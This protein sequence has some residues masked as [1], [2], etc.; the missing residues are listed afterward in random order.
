MSSGDSTHILLAPSSGTE[1]CSS[2]GAGEQ[3]TRLDAVGLC[4]SRKPLTAKTITARY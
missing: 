3:L 2:L 4:V 1:L